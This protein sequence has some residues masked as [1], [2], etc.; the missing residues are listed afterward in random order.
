MKNFQKELKE[1][2]AQKKTELE[3]NKSFEWMFHPQLTPSAVLVLLDASQEHDRKN[4]NKYEEY[5]K[6]VLTKRSQKVAHHKG[7]ISF[8][9]GMVEKTDES[10]WHTALRE[11]EEEIGLPK[12]QTHFLGE[13]P[14]LVTPTGFRIH[15][16]VGLIEQNIS[17]QTNTDEIETLF[18]VPLQFFLDPKNRLTK[19]YSV[20]S[21]TVLNPKLP[22]LFQ[23]YFNNEQSHPLYIYQEHEI[24]G[25]TARILD[26]FVE[27]IR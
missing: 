27:M 1:K 17:W 13:L 19:T 14:P 16:F 18:Q 22:P 3:Q 5:T 4:I 11:S 23:N 7:Q 15:P 24:W 2:L 6:V 21:K 12:N 20:Q 10:L 8:P 25:A 26:S 9:G